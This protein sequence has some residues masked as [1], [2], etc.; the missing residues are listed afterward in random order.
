MCHERLYG[1]VRDFGTVVQIGTG[2]K[3]FTTSVIKTP[4]SRSSDD[5]IRQVFREHYWLGGAATTTHAWT[6]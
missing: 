2:F 1:S 6:P 4:T 3:Q 5:D